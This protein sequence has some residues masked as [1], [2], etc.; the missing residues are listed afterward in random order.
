MF[1]SQN[2]ST[3][4]ILEVESA[5]RALLRVKYPNLNSEEGGNLNDLVIK[6]IS[7]LAS[8]IKFE[9][10]EIRS[11]L[12]LGE[13]AS[14]DIVGSSDILEDL[15]SNFLVFPREGQVSRGLVTF[16]FLD[17]SFR[18]I[19]ASLTLTRGEII[20]LKLFDSTQDIS[21]T[22]DDYLEETQADGSTFYTVSIL[23]D[24]LNTRETVLVT[25]GTFSSSVIFPGIVD[26]INISQFLTLN[27]DSEGSFDILERMRRAITHRGFH[28]AV[29]SQATILDEGSVNVKKIVSVGAGDRE[30]QRDL[31]PSTISGTEFHSLGMVNIFCAS[32]LESSSHPVNNVASLPALPFCLVHKAT[33]GTTSLA[34]V[35]DFTKT[36]GTI[37]RVSRE[38]SPSDF[39]TTITTQTLTSTTALPQNSISILS[40]SEYHTL[41]PGTSVLGR[42][43]IVAAPNEA[44]PDTI[45]LRV[46][47]NIPII[48]SLID[49]PTYAT[50]ANDTLCISAVPVT[51]II[52]KLKV[53]TS[54][55]AATSSIQSTVIKSLVSQVIEDW[56]E[57][58]A[59]STLDILTPLAV[60]LGG[61]AIDI[62]L[63]EGI[64]YIVHLPDGRDLPFNSKDLLSV[65]DASK[66]LVPSTVATEDLNKMQVSDRVL[67]YIFNSSDLTL[68][69]V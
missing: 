20:S 59:L 54:A 61:S 69:V 8:I 42:Q 13:L 40:Q 52:P 53:S 28:T 22:P 25:P 4:D 11:R 19:P 46:D 10:E 38:Y 18:T 30:M 48:Q 36:D 55:N 62:S 27:P 50:L 15:A 14:S 7:Y 51:L 43:S 9:A 21:L 63:P 16:R 2:I 17:N 24:T 60:L 6:S 32:L 12:Y 41:R 3:R 64:T 66:Q 5:L 26:I 37:V 68:E 34:I 29:A 35:S 47:N 57:E 65:E 33:R 39:T 49:S 45:N 31:L 1:N 23:M 58:R 44:L 67:N 56:V